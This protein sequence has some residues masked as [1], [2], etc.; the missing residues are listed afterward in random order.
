MD[1]AV[2]AAVPA[3]VVRT[4]AGIPP[5]RLTPHPDVTWLRELGYPVQATG[6][7]TLGRPDAA[8]LF[9][10]EE[11]V[12]TTLGLQMAAVSAVAGIE[13]TAVA[14]L[15]KLDQVLPRPQTGARTAPSNPPAAQPG[16]GAAG[17]RSQ[18]A[19]NAR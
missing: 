11:A 10:D 13:A 4:R 14:D 6:G 8:L 16:T 1:A 17:R 2:A 9:D 19:H 15:A 18:R 3:L 5:E 7:S 12:A